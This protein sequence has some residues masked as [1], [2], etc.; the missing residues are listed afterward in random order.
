MDQGEIQRQ[1]AAAIQAQRGGRR[2][3]AV[4]LFQTIIAQAGEQPIALNS[5]GLN[6]LAGRDPGGAASFFRRAIAV[7]PKSPELWMNLAKAM[8]ELGNDA[9]EL[10]ALEGA[11]AI[12]QRHFMALVRLAELFERQNDLQRSAQRWSNVLAMAA[13]IDQSTPAIEMMLE[14]AREQVARY[15]ADFAETVDAGLAESRNGLSTAERRRF[16]ACIDHVLGRRRIYANECAGIHFPFLPADEFFERSHF[17]WL[18]A[19]E[20]NT[21]LIRGE[22]EALLAEDEPGIL[23]YVAMDPGTPANKWSPLDHSLDW[24]AMHLWKDGRRNDAA[25]ARAPKT[26]SLVEALPLSDLPGRTPTV[27][28][29]LL[30][31]GTHLPA[32]T[33][34]SNVRAIIHLPLIVPPGCTFRVGGETRTWEAGKAWAFDD[35][36][37]HE[38]WNRSDQ[39]RAILIFDVWNPYIRDSE[40]ALLREFYQIA[41][42]SSHKG[43]AAIGVGGA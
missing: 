19:F 4:R 8:R 16:D 17:P 9:G 10:E 38:A 24:G 15:S 36:I 5:L 21:D 25:C 43:D 27:F 34:V 2:D 3:E 37:E 41:E 31:P 12:D 20:S 26:A 33:G 30:R 29:S 18:D 14:H 35:T 7:D 39:I 40:K 32:H 22:L 23:P 42:S 1:L 13:M 28:F 6:A 11:L